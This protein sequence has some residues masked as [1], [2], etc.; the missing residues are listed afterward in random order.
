MRNVILPGRFI[1]LLKSYITLVFLMIF[2]IS[3][4]TLMAISSS[5]DVKL[6][7]DTPSHNDLQRGER[8]FKGLLPKDRNYEAC[9]SCHILSK[10]DTMNWNPSAMDIAVKFL[11]KDFADFQAAVMQPNGKKIEASH[12][13]FKIEDEDLKKVKMYLDELASTGPPT[14]GPTIN[15][16]ALFVLLIVL[17]LLALLDLIFFH[18]IK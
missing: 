13:D 8:F 2:L 12:K 5:V 15:Q 16:L 11:G 4:N 10:P 9:V 7:T 17:M 1:L 6:I 18:K 14:A 3:G